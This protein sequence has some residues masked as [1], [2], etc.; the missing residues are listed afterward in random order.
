M[1]KDGARKP[2]PPGGRPPG[3]FTWVGRMFLTAAV[4]AVIA[5]AVVQVAMLDPGVRY[6]MC[7][8]ERIEGRP[9][10]A[11]PAPLDRSDGPC[12]RPQ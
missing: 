10:Q 11:L 9:V 3:W 4:A 7:P 2:H 1:D 5:T 8:V 12:V 6:R